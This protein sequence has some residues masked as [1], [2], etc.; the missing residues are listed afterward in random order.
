MQIGWIDFSGKDRKKSLNVIR[1]L[2]EEGA[3][4]ELG[5]GRVR[6]AF[7]D[8]FFPATSTL[9]TRAKY[10]FLIPYAFKKALADKNLTNSKM[11]IHKVEDE[12]EKE[13]AKSLKKAFPNEDGIIGKRNLPSGWVTRKPSSIYW[14]GLKQTGIFTYPGLSI[15]GY[16]KRA[17]QNRLNAKA[18]NKIKNADEEFDD[19]DA[20][21]DSRRPFWNIPAYDEK[22]WMKEISINLTHDEAKHLHSQIS[23][24]FKGTLYQ[25]LLDNPIGKNNLNFEGMAKFIRPSVSPENQQLIDLAIPFSILVLLGQIRY[26][27][28]FTENKNQNVIEKWDE[29]SPRIPEIASLDIDRMFVC[30]GLVEPQTKRFLKD[31]HKYFLANDFDAVDQLIRTREIN[32]KTKSR[33]KL[34]HANQYSP[35]EIR[36]MYYLDYRFGTARNLIKDILTGEKAHE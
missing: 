13:C 24:C 29:I 9:M 33:A 36:G 11:V 16:V 25:Y 27:L 23:K 28:M 12:I 34:L 35:D 26:N 22:N 1:L 8:K 5:I 17:L 4:D 19:D 20:G 18:D 3:V 21:L 7:A 10:F 31:L 6:D 15:E 30:L 2:D 32:L 14:S